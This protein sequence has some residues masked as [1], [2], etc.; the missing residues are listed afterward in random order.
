MNDAS[1]T[2]ADVKLRRKTHQTI[3]KVQSDIEGFALNTALAAL[4]EHANALQEWLNATGKEGGNSAVYSEAVETMLL[5]LSP[6]APHAA[7]EL[8]SRLGFA[9]SAYVM[10]WPKADETVAREDEVTIPVQVNGK[11]ARTSRGARRQRRSHIA[12]TR[13]KR[14]RREYSPWRQRAKARHHRARSSHQHRGLVAA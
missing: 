4:M 7:D 13:S 8:L 1:L 6:F 5:L 10:A 11:L 14:L 9:E 2:P 3:Q 12:P